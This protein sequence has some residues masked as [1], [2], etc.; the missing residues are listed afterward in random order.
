[1]L[2]PVHNALHQKGQIIFPIGLVY[3]I[4]LS[5]YSCILQTRPILASTLRSQVVSY[6]LHAAVRQ[7][8]TQTLRFPPSTL[9]AGRIKRASQRCQ[10]APRNLRQSYFPMHTS[11]TPP[12]QLQ[13]S[14]PIAR[15]KALYQSLAHFAAFAARSRSAGGAGRITAH[16][17]ADAAA[18]AARL[19]A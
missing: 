11:S 19:A 16:T 14:L 9:G 1:M 18:F 2:Q 7:F 5:A 15:H 12:H 8:S 17:A 13:A 10:P 3:N 6:L 4:I